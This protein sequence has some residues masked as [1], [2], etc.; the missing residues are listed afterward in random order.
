MLISHSPLPL[1]SIFSYYAGRCSA[2]VRIQPRCIRVPGRRLLPR[3]LSCNFLSSSKLSRINRGLRVKSR[4]KS[5]A[6]KF[7]RYI[8]ASSC[9]NRIIFH[10]FD[11]VICRGASRRTRNSFV[12]SFKRG[13][14]FKF[15]AVCTVEVSSG[16]HATS[17]APFASSTLRGKVWYH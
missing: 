12:R 13:A 17:D 9:T 14:A 3:A 10:G 16:L 2:A 5:E 7:T 4:R 11:I 1:A 8:C 15:V 6:Y